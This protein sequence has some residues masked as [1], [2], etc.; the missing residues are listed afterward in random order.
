M[1]Y[2]TNNGIPNELVIWVTDFHNNHRV[3]SMMESLIFLLA[4]SLIYI[5]HGDGCEPVFSSDRD[6]VPTPPST[7]VY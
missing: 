1:I 2:K 7:N 3:A 4:S 5:A 6:Q